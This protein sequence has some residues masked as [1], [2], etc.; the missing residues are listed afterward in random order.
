M[1][2]KKLTKKL[3]LNR[4]TI[5]LLNDNEKKAIRGGEFSDSCSFLDNCF[6][7]VTCTFTCDYMCGLFG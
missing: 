2:R 6:T 1:K 3:S 7:G 5:A 4:E